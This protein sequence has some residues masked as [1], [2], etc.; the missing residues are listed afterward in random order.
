MPGT[1][2]YPEDSGHL[3]QGILES[4]CLEPGILGVSSKAL[5]FRACAAWADWAAHHATIKAWAE[6]R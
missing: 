3:R 4:R 6:G 1:R 2:H 5:C